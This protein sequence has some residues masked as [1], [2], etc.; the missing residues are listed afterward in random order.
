MLLKR[1]ALSFKDRNVLSSQFAKFILTS[2]CG[3]HERRILHPQLQRSDGSKEIPLLA[4]L[5]SCL[6]PRIPLSAFQRISSPNLKQCKKKATT[7][8]HGLWSEISVLVDCPQFQFIPIYFP[9]DSFFNKITE[10]SSLWWLLSVP[11]LRSEQN[12][13]WGSAPSQQQGWS[14]LSALAL[15]QSRNNNGQRASQKHLW[16]R[17]V[18]KC[19][20]DTQGLLF[21]LLPH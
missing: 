12:S 15:K 8:F 10:A 21:S 14:L 19:S 11:N 1:A 6:K 13:S 16:R 18:T 20:S 3:C 2:T 4:L 7:K 17:G 5:A 9:F